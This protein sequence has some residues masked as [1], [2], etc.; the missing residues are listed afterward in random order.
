[1]IIMIRSMHVIIIIPGPAPGSPWEIRKMQFP[2]ASETR[3]PPAGKHG[4][5]HVSC[6]PPGGMHGETLVSGR[7]GDGK[8]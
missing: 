6:V 5:M 1:M 2:R 8:V 7:N 3:N 4:G